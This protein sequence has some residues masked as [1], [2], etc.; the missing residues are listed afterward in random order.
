MAKHT[1]KILRCEQRIHRKAPVLES[2]FNKAE[3]LLKNT[4]FEEY[5]RT[6]ASV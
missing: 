1:L 2:L 4:Y 5:L 6:V 3:D